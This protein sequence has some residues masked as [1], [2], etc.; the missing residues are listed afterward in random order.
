[1]A[2]RDDVEQ[3]DFVVA[4]SSDACLAAFYRAMNA[5][6]AFNVRQ[7]KWTLSVDG[8]TATA[9]YRGRGRLGARL[10]ALWPGRREQE[11]HPIAR[12]LRM[13]VWHYDEVTRSTDCSLWV[14]QDATTTDV[15]APVAP[16]RSYMSEVESALRALDSDLRVTKQ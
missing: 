13:Q 6:S 16:F 15:G 11:W 9:V 8:L 7:A 3:W 14:E 2:A 5:K 10:V 4:A 1:M 12:H